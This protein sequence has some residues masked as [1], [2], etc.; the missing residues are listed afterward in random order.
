MNVPYRTTAVQF[1]YI[2][3]LGKYFVVGNFGMKERQ[4]CYRP[5][6]AAEEEGEALNFEEFH[7]MPSRGT[8][9]KARQILF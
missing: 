5:R 3:T 2:S 4:D 7:G 9:E 1:I 6:A 8:G